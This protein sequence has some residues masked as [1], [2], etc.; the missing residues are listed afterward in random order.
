MY[1][2]QVAQTSIE[3]LRIALDLTKEWD[4]LE[5]GSTLITGVLVVRTEFVKEHADQISTFLDEYKA[6]AEYAN[7][8]VD[9]AA[10][11]IEKYDIVKA[12]IAKKA[13]PYCNITFMEGEEMKA[14]MNGYLQTRYDQ[15]PAAI[16][17]AMPDLSLIH[18]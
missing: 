16:G 7:S 10:T 5:N 14:A 6:S 1:K 17:G 2:R 11:L 12:A 15:A 3:G 8:N 9:D 18:I 4:A 13:L